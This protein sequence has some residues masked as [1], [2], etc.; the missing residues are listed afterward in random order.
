MTRP[1]R[2]FPH[3]PRRITENDRRRSRSILIHHTARGV[4]PGDP[5]IIAMVIQH[6]A[7]LFERLDIPVRIRY[8]NSPRQGLDRVAVVR[9]L[10]FDSPPSTPSPPAI[11]QPD[12]EILQRNI[13]PLIQNPASPISQ[14]DYLHGGDSETDTISLPSFS[15]SL[16]DT[17]SD[18]DE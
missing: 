15:L 16:S 2:R 5:R 12:I 14:E 17:N 6:V 11:V 1:N 13:E 4:S 18:T 9:M 3:P 7:R 10:D 8:N